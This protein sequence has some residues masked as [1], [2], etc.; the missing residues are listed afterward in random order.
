MTS[1]AEGI[2]S[3]G[4]DVGSGVDD[5]GDV[6][7]VGVGGDGGKFMSISSVSSSISMSIDTACKHRWREGSVMLFQV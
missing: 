5:G 4:L 6:G 3:G 7:D 2:C 1:W